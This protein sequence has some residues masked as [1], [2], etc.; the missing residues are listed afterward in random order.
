MKKFLGLTLFL[1]LFI[2]TSFAEDF[3]EI[4]KLES[5]VSEG[6]MEN[7]VKANPGFSFYDTAESIKELQMGIVGARP[8]NADDS[9]YGMSIW[10]N[11]FR[12]DIIKT[13][14]ITVMSEREVFS[15]DALL[16]VDYISFIKK[17]TGIPEAFYNYCRN[18]ESLSKSYKKDR[19]EKSLAFVDAVEERFKKHIL[20]EQYQAYIERFWQALCRVVCSQEIVHAAD[21]KIRYADL[22]KRLVYICTHP[23][24]VRVLKSY[25]IDKLPLKQR[26]LA[27][28]MKYRLHY[29]LKIFVGLRNR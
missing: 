29:L 8:D 9:T 20:P 27:Y 25:P 12:N 4:A 23:L 3:S 7:I 13:N 2:F 10:K 18:G 22:R 6:A 5:S 1:S 19:F 17:A 28:G 24:T 21:N 15:E 14:N 26:V 11:L 16:M